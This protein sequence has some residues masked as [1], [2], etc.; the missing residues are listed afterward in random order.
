M[1]LEMSPRRRRGAGTGFS[2]VEVLIGTAILT[3]VAVGILPLFTSSIRSNR[4]GN[5]ST[6][7]ANFAR[8]RLEEFFELPFNSSNL[9]LTTGTEN[10]FQEYYSVE[11]GEWKVGTPP[12]DDSDPALWTRETRVRQYSVNALADGQLQTGEALVA[13][14]TASEVHLKEIE[15][16]VDSTARA[17]FLGPGKQITLRTL[18]AQ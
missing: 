5:D 14:A 11:E 7:V 2:I 15:V 13:G 17:G 10:L 12:T 8:E 3:I 18:K 4:E 9:T 16:A 6:Q 1:D